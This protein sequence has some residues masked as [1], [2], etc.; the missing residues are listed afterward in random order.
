MRS[1]KEALPSAYTQHKQSYISLVMSKISMF[2]RNI[3]SSVCIDE[4]FLIPGEYLIF[5]SKILTL[6]AQIIAIEDDIFYN[7]FLHFGRKKTD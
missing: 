2:Q 4:Y 1:T 5:I 6:K 3:F 7:N